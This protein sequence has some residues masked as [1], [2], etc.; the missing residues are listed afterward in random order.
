VKPGYAAKAVRG[1]GEREIRE[2]DGFGPWALRIEEAN[3][4]PPRFDPYWGELRSASI[5]AKLPYHVERREALPGSEL[6][7]HLVAVGDEGL[8]LLSLKGASI[9]RRELGFGQLASISLVSALL[10]G[11]LILEEFG[12]RSI[13]LGYNTVSEK[14]IQEIVDQVRRRCFLSGLRAGE[15]ELRPGPDLVAPPDDG[16]ILFKNLLAGLRSRESPLSLIAYQA[17]SRLRPREEEG[18]SIA[19]RVLDGLHRRYFCSVMLLE[20]S[21]E[22]I[23]V[24]DS[25]GMRRRKAR[26]YRYEVTWLPLAGL[27][28]AR[29]EERSVSKGSFE[30]VLRLSASG[31]ELELSF[32]RPP[33]EGLARLGTIVDFHRFNRAPRGPGA[34]S[35]GNPSP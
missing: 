13:D 6:Y 19:R 10:D 29:I 35:I 34:R 21:S 27:D 12:G 1:V 14:L 9:Q 7:E 17:S 28:G 20:A 4:L 33:E 23:L 25:T 30:S 5:V 32:A 26:G 22:L 11:H 16:D 31:R 8:V 24:R 3:D 2:Y 18:R 15:A